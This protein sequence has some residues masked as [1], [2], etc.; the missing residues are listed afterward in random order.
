MEERMFF[1]G[2]AFCTH[3]HI[4]I[5]FL[6][7]LHDY[8]LLEVTS[9]EEDFLLPQDQLDALEK[10]VRLHFDLNINLEGID[11]IYNL[12]HRVEDLQ[13]EV[14]TLRNQLRGFEAGT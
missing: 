5:S 6:H 12:L 9:S 10:M 11:A 2:K 7:S 14:S 1:S 13:R 4:E 8:G 3:H